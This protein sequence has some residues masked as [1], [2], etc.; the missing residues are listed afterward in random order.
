MR[1]F[2]E[3]MTASGRPPHGHPGTQSRG[4]MDQNGVKG[5]ERRAGFMGLAEDLDQ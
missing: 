3:C 2:T 4:F 5:I 1:V